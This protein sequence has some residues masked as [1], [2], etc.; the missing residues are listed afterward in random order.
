MPPL[1]RPAFQS[2]TTHALAFLGVRLL[3]VYLAVKAIAEGVST[4]I[5]HLAGEVPIEPEPLGPMLHFSGALAY[6]IASVLL[7]RFADTLSGRFASKP[8]SLR[9][10]GPTAEPLA[11]LMIALVGALIVM[12]ALPTA[13]LLVKILIDAAAQTDEFMALPLSI[14]VA[15]V[16][17]IQMMIGSLLMFGAGRITRWLQI[18]WHLNDTWS[19]QGSSSRADQVGELVDAVTTIGL[20]HATGLARA[21]RSEAEDV[22]KRVVRSSIDVVMAAVQR[23]G[24]DFRLTTAPDGTVTIAF[25]DMEGFTAMTQRLGDLAAHEVIKIHNAIVRGALKAHCGQEVELQGDGF[26]LAFASADSALRCVGQIHRDCATHSGRPGAEPIRVRVGLHTGIPIKEGDGFFGITV[27]MAARIAAQ[28]QG[29]Q[30]LVS[31]NVRREL[32]DRGAF[33]FDAGREAQLKGLDGV[34]RMYAVQRYG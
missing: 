27:I 5:V 32:T 23:R 14:S 29:G 12:S 2:V 9:A 20:R 28:A 4:V 15:I 22:A 24:S 26:F 18:R 10:A 1:K 8:A 34:H 3:A 7:W 19:T 16:F 13:L 6:L 30:T 33:A 31:E 21:I 17:A 11:R 25:S